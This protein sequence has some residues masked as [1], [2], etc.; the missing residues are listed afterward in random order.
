M[1]VVFKF[2]GASLKDAD[3][4]R[5]MA[6]IVE[7]YTDDLIIVVSA[8]GKTTR[9]LH[10]LVTEYFNNRDFNSDLNL[11]WDFHQQ[12]IRG[13]E[14]E[15]DE[16]LKSILGKISSELNMKLS[17]KPTLDFDYEYDQIVCL[18]EIISS[19]IVSCFLNSEKI[20]NKWFDIRK[21][22]KTDSI[23]RDA[24]IEWPLST[25]NISTEINFKQ[26]RIYITQG[27]I[28]SNEIGHSTTLGLEGSDYTAAALAYMMNAE[29][30]VVWKDVAGFY[31]SDPKEYKDVI[32]L[33]AISY[34]EAVEL[35][36]Y[37]AK[38]IHPKTIKPLENKNIPL[39][40]KSF[41]EPTQT[42]TVI[43]SSTDDK[44]GVVPF[45]P[46]F[47]SKNNQI[48]IS[49]APND[50]SFIAED[51]LQHIFSILAK[52]RIKVNLMQNSAISFSIC[53][54]YDE[55]KITPAMAELKINYKVLYNKGLTLVTI[56]HF[57]EKT[58]S[59]TTLGKE[60]LVHQRSRHIARFVIR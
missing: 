6:N 10:K 26:H 32:K 4:I 28:A 35:A 18:G 55:E 1:A 40:V 11:F 39:W 34:R 48:L 47:I 21:L 52:Y 41:V 5:N 44:L 51:N 42:G 7:S 56:R 37:G 22:L 24:R 59:D 38:I 60:I 3:S 19:A 33:E 45:V 46:V 50:F 14:I 8:M 16:N 57:N 13:L 23:Y 54:D 20:Q 12:I 49:I 17:Q 30:M 29:K 9:A 2:G 58:I 43:K 36:Y 25:E 27:F 15:N 53:T 31:N